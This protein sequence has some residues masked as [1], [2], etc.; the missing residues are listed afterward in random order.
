M[1]TPAQLEAAAASLR[2]QAHGLPELIDAPLARAGCDVWQGPAQVQLWDQLRWWQRRLGSAA[3]ELTATA[4]RLED[5][6]RRLRAALEAERRA[7]EDAARRAEEERRRLQSRP[8]MSG[9][10]R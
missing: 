6:A 1:P 10:V 7:A 9:G 5:E 2:R 8:A 3:E 4:V